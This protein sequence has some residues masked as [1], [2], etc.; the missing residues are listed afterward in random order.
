MVCSR[1]GNG[2]RPVSY[3]H[4]QKTASD[5]KFRAGTIRF[6]L[7]SKAG[8][9]GISTKINREDMAEAVKHA[10]IKDASMLHEL[11]GLGP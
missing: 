7:L 2:L 10:A 11:K 1:R 3:T 5:K 9:A 4:L 6:V 8:E